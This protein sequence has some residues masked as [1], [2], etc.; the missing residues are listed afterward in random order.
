VH[1]PKPITVI[2]ELN[3]RATK[4]ILILIKFSHKSYTST[5][6]EMGTSVSDAQLATKQF[7]AHFIHIN[8]CQ[9]LVAVAYIC[10]THYH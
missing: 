7:N 10:N 4:L 9:C 1:L 3:I 2:I 8:F 6:I 5:V